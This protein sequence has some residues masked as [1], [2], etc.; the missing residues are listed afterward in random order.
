MS[1]EIP[2]QKCPGSE[3]VGLHYLVHNT[4]G[5]V[6]LLCTNGDCDFMYLNYSTN[7]QHWKTKNCKDLKPE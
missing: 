3:K 7:E 4:K 1:E 2:N 6:N 5:S